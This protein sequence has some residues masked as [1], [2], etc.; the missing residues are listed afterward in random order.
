VS[1]ADASKD[2]VSVMAGLM[3]KKMYLDDRAEEK[4]AQKLTDAQV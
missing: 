1:N 4:D 2:N 3:L